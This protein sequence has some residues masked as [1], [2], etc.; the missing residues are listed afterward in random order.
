MTAR[1][2]CSLHEI[3]EGGQSFMPALPSVTN[4][5]PSAYGAQD[6]L[7]APGTTL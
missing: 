2:A 7:E 3:G 4:P 1:P 6:E 5:A